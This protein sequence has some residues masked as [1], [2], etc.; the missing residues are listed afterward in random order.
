MNPSPRRPRRLRTAAENALVTTLAVAACF[1]LAQH[2][3]AARHGGPIVFSALLGL[4]AGLL[5]FGATMAVL[6]PAAR[7]VPRPPL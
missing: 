4:F 7:R 6:A 2:D 5:M 1:S 3:L